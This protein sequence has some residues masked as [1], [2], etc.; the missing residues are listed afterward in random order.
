MKKNL[1]L[2]A[3]LGALAGSAGAQQLNQPNA[4]ITDEAIHADH[5]TYEQLQG[6]IKGLND[7]GKHRIG[8]Y[9]LAKAQCW[10]DVSLQEYSRNDRSAF[11]QAA[12][13]ESRKIADYL[14]K[15]ADVKAAGNPANQTPL[16]NDAAK[17]RP[18][19]WDAAAKLKTHPGF[20]C[21]EQ[22]TACAEVELVHAGNEFNQ[23][24]W[25]H[26]KPYIQLAEDMIADA[27]RAAE[28]CIPPPVAPPP[29]PPVVLAPEPVNL[30]ANVLFNFD[31][32]DMG[33]VR[34][35]TKDQLDALINQVK[36]AGVT[37][38][39]IKLTGHADRIAGSNSAYNTKLSQDRVDTIKNYM[40]AAGVPA[41]VITTDFKA[42]AQEVKACERNKFRNN[43]ELQECLLPNRRVEVQAVGQRKR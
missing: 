24:Q 18:D 19:L 16:V 4:R 23:Q 25:R 2:A 12:F 20:R 13:D 6:R 38:S 14:E 27:Q 37:V 42:A 28:A 5:K 21:A 10:I 36:A 7:T 1:I 3:L 17:L 15:S 31:K 35:Y 11:P 43:A 39:S 41:S 26:A 30:S 22:K 29:A 9:S 34:A 33:N 40:V 32:R 8:S